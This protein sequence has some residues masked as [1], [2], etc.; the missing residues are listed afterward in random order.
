MRH[1]EGGLTS[2]AAAL[3]DL[4]N[5]F[6][7]AEVLSKYFPAEVAMHSFQNVTGSELKKA[8]WKLLDK[9][10]KVCA[11]S[12]LVLMRMMALGQTTVGGLERWRRSCVCVRSTQTAVRGALCTERS[13]ALSDADCLWPLPHAEARHPL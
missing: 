9:F 7:V 11:A 5:G 6:L 1:C 13:S 4:A 10:L 3:R 8:S 2:V 12:A